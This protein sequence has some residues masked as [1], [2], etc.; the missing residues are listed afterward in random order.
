MSRNSVRADTPDPTKYHEMKG[1]IPGVMI[2]RSGSDGQSLGFD[3]NK[4]RVVVVDPGEEGGGFSLDIAALA[5]SKNSFNSAA[6][7]VSDVSAF[8]KELSK[9][10]SPVEETIPVKVIESK[11]MT[12]EA[13]KPLT[14]LPAI[15]ASSSDNDHSKTIN[16]VT[17]ALSEEAKTASDQFKRMQS[18]SST[19][20][21]NI[22]HS[23]VLQQTQT[24][25]LLIEKMNQLSSVV[26][27]VKQVEQ[28]TKEISS[29]ESMSLDEVLAGFQIPFFKP[30]PERPQFET[31]FEMQ[32]LGT[33]AAK[34]HAVIVGESCLALVY[35]TRFEDGFQYLPPNLGEEQ[36]K[37]SVPKLKAEYNCS[38]LGLH[39]SLGCL[40]VVILIRHEE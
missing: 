15:N 39:W 30:K 9:K 13:I 6:S 25:N 33:M 35:D 21:S 26:Q 40:D 18:V 4:P 1:L 22:L 23:Q 31:Y 27:P 28:G 8:Y 2:P 14:G 24:I 19:I 7:R 12:M 38:S 32:K 34:Y 10:M 3:A 5:K 11:G 16:Q 37:I 29:M 17:S 20:D 36:I